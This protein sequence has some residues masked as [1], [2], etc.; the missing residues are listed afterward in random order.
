MH[1]SIP[2]E[3]WDFHERCGNIH[4]AWKAG[5]DDVFLDPCK[6]KIFRFFESMPVTLVMVK[7]IDSML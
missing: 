7:T 2:N 1:G 4:I 5:L 3:S 6:A